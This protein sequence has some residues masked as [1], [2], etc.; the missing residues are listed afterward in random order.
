MQ[1]FVVAVT[2]LVGIVLVVAAVWQLLN[3]WAA[4]LLVGVILLLGALGVE[5]ATIDR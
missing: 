3:G 4:L 2:Q 5:R 1:R